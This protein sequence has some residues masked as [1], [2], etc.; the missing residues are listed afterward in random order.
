MD[1]LLKPAGDGDVLLTAVSEAT[2]AQPT[3]ST[4]GPR[5][6]QDV[7]VPD[8]EASR[9]AQ[10]PNMASAPSV[11]TAG[12]EDIRASAPAPQQSGGGDE[13]Q[14]AVLDEAALTIQAWETEYAK[15]LRAFIPSPRAAKRFSNIYRIMKATV[16]ANEL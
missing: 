1:A 10:Q 9:L 14:G 8:D 7:A 11:P 12:A 6:A 16:P 13:S 4:A 15:R 5:I 2:P 3:A